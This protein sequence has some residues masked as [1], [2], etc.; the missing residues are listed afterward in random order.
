M[1]GL[2]H[3]AI[4]AG[5][6]LFV[7]KKKQECFLWSIQTELERDRDRELNQYYAKP[8]TLQWEWDW[9]WELEH[10]EITV[11]HTITHHKF[12]C[13]FPFKVTR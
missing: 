10:I 7:I 9:D 1:L 6:Y 4:L 8:F 11:Q 12:P 2:F 5:N 3:L 13:K